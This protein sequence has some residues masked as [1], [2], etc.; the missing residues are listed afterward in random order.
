MAYYEMMPAGLP[1][2]LQSGMDSVLNKKFGTATSYA[3]GTWP[4]TVNLMGPLPEATASGAI[5][6]FEDG[7]DDVPTKSLVVTI[8]PTLSGVSSVTATQTGRNLLNFPNF[9]LNFGVTNSAEVENLVN[10]PAGQYTITFDIPTN[11]TTKT[12]TFVIRNEKGAG[13]TQQAISY[14][15]AGSTA[16]KTITFTATMPFNYFYC[17]MASS[18]TTGNTITIENIMMVS[19]STAHAY[20]PY[21]APTQ[22]TASLGR[23]I[24]GGTA[25]IV[26]GKCEP[27][28][29]LNTDE[30]VQRSGY[31]NLSVSVSNNVL[32]L[33]GYDAGGRFGCFNIQTEVGKD[34]TV[35]YTDRSNVQNVRVVESDTEPT[36]WINGGS[37][38]G[39]N[40]AYTY[41]A[42]KPWVQIWVEMT[43]DNATVTDLQVELGSTA[44]A[45]NPYFEPFTFDGQEVPTRLGYNAFW[46]DSGD[47]EVTYRADISLAL[48]A[49]SGSRGLMMART[50]LEPETEPE[51]TIEETPEEMER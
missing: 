51:E 19:G 25:D 21:T 32:T 49:V 46:A 27:I 14:I 40:S 18:E 24:Y 4:D 5:A 17:Y 42:T 7:A 50:Q 33:S 29:L 1:A 8:P 6:T 2:G 48:Q 34:Y 47:T 38:V 23:T 30:F 13:A 39:V 31:N 43:A 10:F 35:K 22:Y 41:T 9:T 44:S 28:N 45:Y 3:P 11:T 20:E 26:N 16:S 36:N 37:A 12:V 15:S